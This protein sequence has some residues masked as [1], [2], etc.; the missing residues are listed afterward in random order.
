LA[1][2][3]QTPAWR[4]LETSRARLGGFSIAQ[5]VRDPRR[6]AA[7]TLDVDGTGIALDLS[8]NLAD[9][10]VRAQLV[11]LAR[12]SDVEGWRA[13]LF[14]GEPVNATE[15][16]PA[17][18]TALRASF[19][20][21]AAAALPPGERAEGAALADRQRAHALSFAEE[22][23]A[24]RVRGASGAPIDTVIC[25]GIGG[26]D[27]GPRLAT[28][29]LGAQ[30]GPRLHFV[31]NI[32]PVELDAALAQAR[33]DSTL[34][35]AISKS[36]STQETLENVKAALAW[37]RA[38]APALDTSKHLAAVTSQPA[39]AAALG[40]PAERTF[41]FA[42]WVGG[43]YS[44]WSA[45]GLPVAIAHGAAAFED[46]LRGAATMDR[47]FL[48]APLEAN[49]PVQL[50][51]LGLW[52]S[53]FLGARSRAVMSYAQRLRLLPAYLQ[54]LEMES[55]GKRVDRD[56]SAV[57][58]ETAPAV[59]GDAGTTAQHSVFQFL[60]QGTQ[61]VPVDFVTCRAFATS[62][63]VRERLL[64]ENAVAQADALAL[65]DAAIGGRESRPQHAQTPGNRPS[66]LITLAQ[67]DAFSLGALLALYEHRTFVQGVVWRINPFDQ[68][69]VEIGKQL[70][71][72]RLKQH[73]K[74]A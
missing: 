44:L 27:L 3:T 38:H 17:W 39:R 23:R 15:K 2:L 43:R 24:G 29:A 55:D 61:V 54:Q 49:A 30:R 14:A 65:G 19:D 58:Y 64:Y 25:F 53:N 6:A 5:A 70:V 7:W 10:T 21:A 18:H 67:L 42:D 8:R 22:L 72:Q 56:G 52:C 12:A 34:L 66:N 74:Q 35:L 57:D 36:F 46:L 11:E 69:G 16:R 32:D 59:W 40:V 63:D 1:S 50:A 41:E 47:H 60:H 45:C 13:A 73:S 68:W 71:N 26:S 37:F 48:Q 51:L 31:A 28:E 62:A 9:D 4:A 20:S 33:P